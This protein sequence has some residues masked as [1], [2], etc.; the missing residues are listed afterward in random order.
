LTAQS[1][2]T[3]QK[4]LDSCVLTLPK[5]AQNPRNAPTKRPRTPKGSDFKADTIAIVENAP[6]NA[7]ARCNT[8]LLGKYPLMTPEQRLVHLAKKYLSDCTEAYNLLKKE[9]GFDD[10]LVALRSG[11]ISRFGH[12]ETIVEYQFHGIGC[13]IVT[14]KTEVDFDF[15]PEGTIRLFDHYHLNDYLECNR[16][17][18]G[19]EMTDNDIGEGIEQAELDGIIARPNLPFSGDK[20]FLVERGD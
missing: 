1:K 10:P 17:R 11:K 12:T 18:L 5:W 3:E 19:C 9:L 6:E 4:R 8:K 13:Y 16:E 7:Q 2:K 20:Y 15:D 14:A